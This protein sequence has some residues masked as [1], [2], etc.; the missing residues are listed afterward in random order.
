MSFT[1]SSP[2]LQRTGGQPS[3]LVSS[4]LS[5]RCEPQEQTKAAVLTPHKWPAPEGVS[6]QSAADRHQ[7][8]KVASSLFAG[9]AIMH[10]YLTVEDKVE[11]PRK[12]VFDM[13]STDDRLS[14]S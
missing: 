11:G 13:C 9:T 4:S 5:G 7:L 12:P 3:L 2:H 1:L 14:A 10:T 6:P 8:W